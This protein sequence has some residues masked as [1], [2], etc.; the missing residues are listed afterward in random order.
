MEAYPEARE[1]R[2]DDFPPGVVA[3]PA[4]EQMWTASAIA[5][6]GALIR[7]PGTAAIHEVCTHSI[8]RKRNVMIDAFLKQP[9]MEWICFM[10]SDMVPAADTLVQLLAADQDIVSGLYFMRGEPYHST[11]FV[12]TSR[13]DPVTRKH[14]RKWLHHDTPRD[15]LVQ[16]DY[17]GAGCLLVRRRV[18]E[19]IEAPWFEHPEPGGGEDVY[20]CDKAIAAGFN[21][22]VH[23][24]VRPGHIGVAT[25]NSDFVRRYHAAEAEPEPGAR[26]QE[27]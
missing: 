11:A 27:D 8:A 6:F 24:G 18:L 20:F 17:A 25:V 12:R 2:L 3:V 23:T 1:I 4:Q 13:P 10:D 26:E 21:I 14:D 16:V 15:R 7:P 5:I 9:Q 22:Y 19:T